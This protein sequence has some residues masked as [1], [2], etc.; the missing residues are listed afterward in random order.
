VGLDGIAK[1]I[2]DANSPNVEVSDDNGN[3]IPDDAHAELENV[4][5]GTTIL[6]YVKFGPGLKGQMVPVD[7]ICENTNEAEADIGGTITSGSASAT[8]KVQ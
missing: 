3:G 8:L 5:A 7:N 4:L 6:M 1:Q 2:A